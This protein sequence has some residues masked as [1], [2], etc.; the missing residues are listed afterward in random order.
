MFIARAASSR[1]RTTRKGDLDSLVSVPEYQGK[2]EEESRPLARDEEKHG[3]ESVG[4]VFRENELQV[5]T[6]QYT[7][8]YSYHMRVRLTWFSL[9]QRSIGL[10]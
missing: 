5:G 9:L 10:I 2:I 1:N 3:E 4:E 6:R 8:L 7:Q